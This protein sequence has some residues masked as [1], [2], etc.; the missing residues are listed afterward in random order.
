M[1]LVYA[2]RMYDEYIT[3][4]V[5]PRQNY[6]NM[7]LFFDVKYEMQLPKIVEESINNHV[8]T[9]NKPTNAVV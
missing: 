4:E 6:L 8:R 3:Y 2:V 1:P 7:W 9:L 5:K